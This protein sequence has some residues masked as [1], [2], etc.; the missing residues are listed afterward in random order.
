VA[1]ALVPAKQAAMSDLQDAPP[2]AMTPVLVGLG[3]RLHAM[4]LDNQDLL[5]RAIQVQGQVIQ[6][7]ASA[8]KPPA[9]STRYDRSGAPAAAAPSGLALSTRA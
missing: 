1:A 8:C 3:E 4:A 5:A 2:V 6:I 7:V 9:G